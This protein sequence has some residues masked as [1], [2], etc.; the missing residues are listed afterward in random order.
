MWATERTPHTIN[1]PTH[2][3]TK[4]RVEFGERFLQKVIDH[5]ENPRNVG[6]LD[7]ASSDVGTGNVCCRPSLRM[8]KGW[9]LVS[10]PHST[11]A[12]RAHI[13]T[14]PHTKNE[15]A[16]LAAAAPD[17]LSLINLCHALLFPRFLLLF[18]Y[19]IVDVGK[20]DVRARTHT[21]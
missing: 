8:L 18:L 1:Q 3:H 6:S 16:F 7:K 17:A 19:A 9:S 4:F 20:A 10:S 15:R 13:R 21:R 2:T 12:Q 5:Y 14:Q 11:S